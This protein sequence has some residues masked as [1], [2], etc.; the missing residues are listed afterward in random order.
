MYLLG[1]QLQSIYKITK[2]ESIAHSA[3]NAYV[4][5]EVGSIRA[6]QEKVVFSDLVPRVFTHIGRKSL[7]FILAKVS[8]VYRTKFDDAPLVFSC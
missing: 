1:N 5:N 7:V 4:S 6:G 3:D 2:H 8:L